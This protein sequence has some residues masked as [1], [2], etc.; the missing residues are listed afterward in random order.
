MGKGVAMQPRQNPQHAKALA[1]AARNAASVKSARVDWLSRA[2]LNL[3]AGFLKIGRTPTPKPVK[4]TVVKSPVTTAMIIPF[5][6]E[7]FGIPVDKLRSHDRRAMFSAPRCL[8]CLLARHFT[9][10]SYPEIGRQID[11]HDRTS[12][13][14]DVISA[15]KRLHKN[16]DYRMHHDKLFIRLTKLYGELREQTKPMIPTAS[17]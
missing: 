9:S 17:K 3:P 1:R 16:A 6:A 7:E 8:V 10:E 15:R 13:M 14:N 5:V 12:I 2:P 11:G 4:P